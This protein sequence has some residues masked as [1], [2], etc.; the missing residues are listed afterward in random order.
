MTNLDLNT[1]GEQRTFE[2]IPAGTICTLQ[3]TVRPGGVGDD[4]YLTRAKD[5]ASD[6]LDCEFIVVDGPYAK[7]R[8][9]QRFTLRGTT[10]KHAQAGEI[11]CITL[12]AIVESAGGI[13]PDDKS[14]EAQAKR[15]PASLRELDGLRFIARIGVKRPENGFEAK[16]II[17]EVIT[18]ER[19]GWTQ[20]VQVQSGMGSTAAAGTGAPAA[21]P[22]NAIARPDWAKKD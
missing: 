12:R 14:E 19:K 21:Q 13:R 20:P 10:P 6:G 4:G 1:A 8:L 11:S 22:A 7:R 5:G 16:N 9:W 3:L 18:P 17:T 15:K 2:I